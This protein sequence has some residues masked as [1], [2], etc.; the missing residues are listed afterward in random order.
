MEELNSKNSRYEFLG[1]RLRIMK[2]DRERLRNIQRNRHDVSDW[3]ADEVAF[4]RR[5]LSKVILYLTY[6]LNLTSRI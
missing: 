6:L 1:R 4:V 2:N 5:A 3:S